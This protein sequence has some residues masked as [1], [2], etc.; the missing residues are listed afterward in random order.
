MAGRRFVVMRS[1]NFALCA[2]AVFHGL[3]ICLPQASMFT[4]SSTRVY[5][6]KEADNDLGID[7]LA[8]PAAVTSQPQVSTTQ[9]PSLTDART[10]LSLLVLWF[11]LSQKPRTTLP[12]PT[13]IAQPTSTSTVAQPQIPIPVV[14]LPPATTTP[15]TPTRPTIIIEVPTEWIPNADEGFSLPTQALGG[16]MEVAGESVM[17]PA[18]SWRIH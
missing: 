17:R 15:L 9:V 18:T 5:T 1:V 12:S 13:P 3:A 4:E 2:F 11:L 10:W 16:I 6:D 8:Q 7:P 14:S